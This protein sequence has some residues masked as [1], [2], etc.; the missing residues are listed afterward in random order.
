M[1]VLLTVGKSFWSGRQARPYSRKFW[2]E[3]QRWQNN[4]DTFAHT[5]HCRTYK[6]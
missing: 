1:T 5:W 6:L 3:C 4:V 2:Q